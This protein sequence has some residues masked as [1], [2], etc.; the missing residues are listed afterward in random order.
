MT[1]TLPPVLAQA[2]AE[3]AARQPATESPAPDAAAAA[4]RNLALA[5][6]YPMGA[7][8]LAWCL[9][10]PR[11]V[12]AYGHLLVQLRQAMAR[13]ELI[14]PILSEIWCSVPGA[15]RVRALPALTKRATSSHLAEV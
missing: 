1:A 11:E 15:A 7:A 5:S 9:D 2:I 13:R 14:Q 3:Q 8:V 10:H 4:R 6:S 12:G